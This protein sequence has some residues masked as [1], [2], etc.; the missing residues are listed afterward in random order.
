MAATAA[1]L[2]FACEREA[3]PI[4]QP[5]AL[6]DESPFDYPLALWDQ[7]VEGET[8]LM[9]RVDE[10]GNVDSTYVERSSGHAEFDSAAVRGARELRFSPARRG[11]RPVALWSRLPV[12][13]ARDGGASARDPEP[14]TG[15]S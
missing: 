1:L 10:V 9:V 2:P 11:D 6:P 4:Q 15:G 8:L 14:P 7:G 5:V 3:L 13:F 12:R